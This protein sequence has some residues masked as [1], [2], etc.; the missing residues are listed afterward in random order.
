MICFGL[1][2]RIIIYLFS[3]SV[4]IG[5]FFEHPKSILHK[6]RPDAPFFIFLLPPHHRARRPNLDYNT[7]IAAGEGLNPTRSCRVATAR[8]S[9]IKLRT[10]LTLGTYVLIHTIWCHVCAEAICTRICNSMGFFFAFYV[11]NFPPFLTVPPRLRGFNIY[12]DFC[13]YCIYVSVFCTWYKLREGGENTL[14]YFRWCAFRRNSAAA[15][16]ERV[17]QNFHQFYLLSCYNCLARVAVVSV[18]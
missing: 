18:L 15:G 7:S 10:L 16:V 14:P 17:I 5:P 13:P 1:L 9:G 3:P 12:T 6:K 11:A 4:K 2:H 8:A